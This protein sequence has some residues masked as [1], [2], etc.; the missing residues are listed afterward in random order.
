MRIDVISLKISIWGY[1]QIIYYDFIVRVV[2]IRDRINPIV[3]ISKYLDFTNR[4]YY[5]ECSTRIHRRRQF[6]LEM[7]V[8]NNRSF[9]YF[10]NQFGN[11]SR[12]IKNQVRQE[13]DSKIGIVKS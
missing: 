6:S 8:R 1:K 10:R 13:S 2:N 9:E 12:G 4:F 11:R 5:S 3:T 7:E